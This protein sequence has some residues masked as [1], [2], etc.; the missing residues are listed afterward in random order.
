MKAWVKKNTYGTAHWQRQEQPT[1]TP[2]HGWALIRVR[3][4]DITHSECV[5]EVVHAGGLNLPV[6]ARI[7][8]LRVGLVEPCVDIYAEYAL[9]PHAHLFQLNSRLPWDLL[10][11]LPALVRN[12][13]GALQ[14]G[15]AIADA[16]SL[17]IRGGTSTVGLIVLALAK[18]TGLR[19]G[20]TTRTSAQITNLIHAGADEVWI[21]NGQVA[22]QVAA[23]IFKPYDRVLELIGTRTLVD[24]LSCVGSGGLVCMMGTLG[25]SASLEHFNPRVDMPTSVK[26]TSYQDSAT[27]L[28][29]PQLQA[30]VDLVTAARLS[31]PEARVFNFDDLEAAQRLSD[32]TSAGSSI[33]VLGPP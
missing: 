25:G 8:A 32:L 30:H 14:V 20:A 24:S 12:A 1:P 18:A 15:L 31:L 2:K 6:G 17:L 26:L 22:P 19:V 21:D 27:D 23:S 9:I 3:A 13:H 5:G 4:V 33:M 11:A 29:G 16:E 10:A 7:A 28:T